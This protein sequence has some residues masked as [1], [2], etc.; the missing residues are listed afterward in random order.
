MHEVIHFTE[1]MKEVYF[2]FDI[3][4][5]KPEVFCTVF[6]ENQICIAVVDSNKFS[7]R[8]KHIAI[9]YHHLLGFVQKKII[10]ICYIDKREQT[11]EIFTKTLDK[12]LFI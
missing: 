12:E 4:L 7:P 10:W 6:E 8:T 9:K 3:H 11:S 2:I 1:L 5:P